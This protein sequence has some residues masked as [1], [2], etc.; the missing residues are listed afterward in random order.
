[1]KFARISIQDL[2]D[3]NSIDPELEKVF[4]VHM[5]NRIFPNVEEIFMNQQDLYSI[6]HAVD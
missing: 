1:M 3:G 6:D 5:N 4:Y 2:L